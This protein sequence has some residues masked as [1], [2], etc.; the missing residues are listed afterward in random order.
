ML[1]PLIDRAD[2]LSLGAGGSII[3]HIEPDT[4]DPRTWDMANSKIVHLHLIDAEAFEKV[5]D[6]PPPSTPI[7]DETYA[8]MGLP[9]LYL[10]RDELKAPGVAGQ[11]EQ[12]MGLKDT[13]VNQ[14][15]LVNGIR[16]NSAKVPPMGLLKSGA[17]GRLDEDDAG[18][19]EEKDADGDED[20]Q[21]IKGQADA[22]TKR[23]EFPLVLL[24]P[25]DTFGLI[26]SL[27]DEPYF[28]E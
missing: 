12:L 8:S 15:F 23:F 6:F 18:E 26:E 25:D 13:G 4:S 9:F 24:D 5:T 7:T 3:Q 16:R 21:G 17:W 1:R 11:W 2:E 22:P 14:V 27:E 10:W 19:D 20:K 28:N